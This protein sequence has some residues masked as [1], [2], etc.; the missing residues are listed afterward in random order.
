MGTVSCCDAT[1]VSPLRRDGT[2][3]ALTAEEPGVTLSRARR[4]KERAYP[5]LLTG[6]RARLVVLAA[7]VGGRWSDEAR[8][9]LRQ[10]V[11]L[12]VRQAPQVLRQAARLA[13]QQGWWKLLS[14]AVQRAVTTTLVE[15]QRPAMGGVAGFEDVFLADVLESGLN[16][17]AVSRLP[18][19]S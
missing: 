3:N 12:R 4:R 6:G 19:R 7:E 14:V 2:A 17:P 18:L 13:W 8:S 1:L 9:F 11:R 16:A 10:L 5:E 15:P